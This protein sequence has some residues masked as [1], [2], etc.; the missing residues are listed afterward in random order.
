MTYRFVAGLI[1]FLFFQNGYLSAQQDG[2]FSAPGENIQARGAVISE[3]EIRLRWSPAG[4]KAWID[5]I[6][7]G[8]TVE[9]YTMMI[10]NLWQENPVKQIMVRDLKPRP[11]EQWKEL[12]ETSDYAAVIA[13][14]FYG[15]D[16]ELS[17]AS[18][19]MGYIIN[20]AEELQQRFSTSVFMAE[21]DYNAAG[22]AGWAFTDNTVKSNERYLY[23]IYLN[24]PGKAPADTAAVYIGVQDK[25]ELPKPIGLNAIFADR[26]V[27]LSW[28]YSLLSDFYHSYHVERMSSDEKTFRRITDLPVTPLDAGVREIFYADSL[29]NNET[30][31]TYRITGLTG[32]DQTGPASDTI[33]GHGYKTAG[34]IPQIYAGYFTEKDRAHLF[35]EFECDDPGQ[36]RKFSIERASAID[37]EYKTI[38]D[39]V[40]LHFRDQSLSLPDEV[41]YIKLSA[42][43][44]DDSRQESFPFLLN[45][46]DSIPPAVPTGLKA[47]IDSVGVAC[48]SWNANTEPDLRGYRLLRSFTKGGEKSSFISDFI[49]DNQY[50]DTLSLALSN[51]E[52][53]YALTAVDMR[54]NESD[55]C[56]D[57]MAV[58]PNLATPAEPVIVGYQPAGNKVTVSW[59][60]DTTRTGIR[61]DLVRS[62]ENKPEYTKTV[63]SGNGSVNTYTDDVPESG[64]YRYRVFAYGPDGKKST[65]P[66]ALTLDIAVEPDLNEVGGFN[67]YT[68]DAGKYIE[69]FWKK[70]AKARLYRIYK[71]EK[72]KKMILWQ[73][74]DAQTNRIVDEIVSPGTDYV[75]TILFITDEGRTSKAKT[76]TVNY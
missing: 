74:V 6:N 10:D 29:D 51:P 35:W 9:R 62:V 64:R 72:D 22:Y 71:A 12:I 47:M 76:I 60:T 69:L 66:Q 63:F 65:S 48:L 30:R 1:L 39:S 67:A 57:V 20:R 27:V 32:F 61:Y 41:N 31:Y 3:T 23:R 13:Q 73:E 37:G 5:G 15:E 42:V 38:E 53:Y 7:N 11:L 45:R 52:V 56:P 50:T 24:R 36:I 17:S 46:I 68:D 58:K 43:G 2:E 4:P 59:I 70:N 25:K 40:A 33:S 8:Y 26:S 28:N 16:F 34:C 18:G 75:Y 21:Y 14:A 55:P 44:K 49:T 54:Y 19:G